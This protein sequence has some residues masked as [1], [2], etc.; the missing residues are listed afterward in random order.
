MGFC[1]HKDFDLKQS[2]QCCF[3]STLNMLDERELERRSSCSASSSKSSM[4]MG[5]E[6]QLDNKMVD[7]RKYTQQNKMEEEVIVTEEQVGDFLV[8]CYAQ[9]E[10]ETNLAIGNT[11][12]KVY[13]TDSPDIYLK[14]IYFDCLVISRTKWIFLVF[15]CPRNPFIPGTETLWPPS[16][17]QVQ[18]CRSNQVGQNHF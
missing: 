15:S 8:H 1:S 14:S 18:Q 2:L 6:E 10:K 17:S 7:D 3:Q 9:K 11:C 12:S 4:L 16:S 5:E 13:L